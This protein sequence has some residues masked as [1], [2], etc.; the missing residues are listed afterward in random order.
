LVDVNGDL[1]ADYCRFVGAYPSTITLS[2]SLAAADGF[3][4]D[5]MNS[6]TPYD[7]GGGA[8]SFRGMADVN[9]D[10]RADYARYIANTNTLSAGLARWQIRVVDLIASS[11]SGET[12]QDSEPFLAIDPSDPSGQR[13]AASAFTPNPDG[14]TA[15][16]APIFVTADGG[17]T[18]SLLSI[19]PS[20]ASTS[21]ITLAYGPTGVLYAAD[22]PK[23][24]ALFPTNKLR[25][26]P[27]FPRRC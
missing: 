25:E 4:N 6:S 18:W 1:R 7:L 3:G 19:V 23:P 26:L 11:Q 5:L 17:A 16:T 9:G 22:I 20:Q 10:G 14:P 8:S 24:S 13:M 2:C 12:N 15:T 21:D 27:T